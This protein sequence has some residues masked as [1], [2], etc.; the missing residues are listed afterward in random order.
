MRETLDRGEGGLSNACTSLGC[1]LIVDD[2][3]DTLMPLCEILHEWGY[4]VLYATSGKSALEIL[5]REE[6]DLLISDLSMPEMDGIELIRTAGE[7]D[8][9]LVCIVITG[10]GTVQTAVEAMSAGAFDFILKPFDFKMMRSKISRAVEI[11]KL[12]NSEEIYRSIVENF[13]SEM[14]CRFLPDGTLTFVNQAFSRYFAQRKQ[15]I[16][17]GTYLAYSHEG[18]RDTVITTLATLDSENPVAR[19]E[20]RVRVPHGEIRWQKWTF[21]AILDENAQV[22]VIQAIGAD[23]HDLKMAEEQLTKHENELKKK[24]KD[25]EDFYR[26]AVTR[27]LR[28]KDL[29]EE[30]KVLQKELERYKNR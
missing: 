22:R 25:L 26:M 18:D 7:R 8:G 2:E 13:Q 5:E 14:I 30:I 16:A 21:T 12:R 19:I 9:N 29:K 17:G 11:R 3:I 15:D 23:I 27:E 4:E 28:M 1:L 10:H 20:Y 24:I 6:I